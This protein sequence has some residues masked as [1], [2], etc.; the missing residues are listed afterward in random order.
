MKTKKFHFQRTTHWFSVEHI[1]DDL[2]ANFES[3][4]RKR[5]QKKLHCPE[6]YKFL[7][8]FD[9]SKDPGRMASI[10]SDDLQIHIGIQD[11]S[12]VCCGTHALFSKY[13]IRSPRIPISTTNNMETPPDRFLLISLFNMSWIIT[14]LHQHGTGRER[15]KKGGKD[16]TSRPW[17]GK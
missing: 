15:E 7:Y 3:R 6:S 2:T 5:G 1:N 12:F 8:S 16:L 10:R 11:T 17:K 9:Y 4:K 13:P 14:K